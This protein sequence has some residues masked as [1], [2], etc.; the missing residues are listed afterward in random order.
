MHEVT[1]CFTSASAANFFPARCFL[2]GPKGWKSLVPPLATR[3]M[4]DY[5]DMAG[6]LWT[7]L[8]ACTWLVSGL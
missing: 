6:R 4:A 2:K 8:L 3:L 1:T 5:G 7:I